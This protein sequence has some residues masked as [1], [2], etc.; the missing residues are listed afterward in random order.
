MLWV[1][2]ETTGTMM[3]SAYLSLLPEMF[4]SFAERRTW[5]S[6]RTRS[7]WGRRRPYLLFATLPTMLFLALLFNAPS[8]G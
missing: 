2:W 3:G 4:R 7:R 6:D 1:L 5:P 8:T